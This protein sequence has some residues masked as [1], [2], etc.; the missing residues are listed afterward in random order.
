MSRT[1]ES[2]WTVGPSHVRKK[3]SEEKEMNGFNW[4]EER[5]QRLEFRGGRQSET[6]VVTAVGAQLKEKEKVKYFV[7]LTFRV[8]LY[9]LDNFMICCI[10]YPN[11]L[12][13]KVAIKTINLINTV[14]KS[15]VASYM[16]NSIGCFAI[17][18]CFHFI[19]QENVLLLS[20]WQQ[21]IGNKIVSVILLWGEGPILGK[22][23]NM[24]KR[25]WDWRMDPKSKPTQ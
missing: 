12:F 17:K 7:I 10:L 2:Q 15:T 13:E 25:S 18:G 4:C 1:F 11:C 8:T 6:M 20:I 24:L 21:T 19:Y 22:Y 9:Y 23:N 16:V 5:M 14:Q 3:K